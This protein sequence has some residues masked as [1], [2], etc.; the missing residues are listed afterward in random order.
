MENQS[1][2][3]EKT[4]QKKKKNSLSYYFGGKM[5]TEGFIVKQFRLLLL[6]FFL[7]II[8]ITNRYSCAKQLTEMD[9]LKR[10]LIDLRNEH[11]TLTYELTSHSGQSNV[12]GLLKN[13]GIELKKSNTA[14]VYQIK[15]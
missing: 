15:K 13:Y 10:E 4:G 2:E 1:Y 8:F 12:E 9:R 3:P 5:L 7:T 14:T 6:I 11:I